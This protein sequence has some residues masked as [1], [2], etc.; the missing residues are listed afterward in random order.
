MMRRRTRGGAPFLVALHVAFDCTNSSTKHAGHVSTSNIVPA[1]LRPQEP[2]DPTVTPGPTACSASRRILFL[3]I[4]GAKRS[5]HPKERLLTDVR[6]A[7][8]PQ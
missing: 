7:T 5:T 8:F 6:R 3:F 1:R 2:F 4:G